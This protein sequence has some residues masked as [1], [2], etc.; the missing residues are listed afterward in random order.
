LIVFATDILPL[1]DSRREPGG[2]LGVTGGVRD[3]DLALESGG[4]PMT[5]DEGLNPN[6]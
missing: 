2:A 6:E 1:R 3:G 4:D 5:N